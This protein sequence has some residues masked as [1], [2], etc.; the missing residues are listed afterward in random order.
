MMNRSAPQA[1]IESVPT[2][3][4]SDGPAVHEGGQFI[5]ANVRARSDLGT[6]HRGNSHFWL[7]SEVSLVQ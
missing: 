6:V 3:V 4:R 1:S 5:G 2:G 7:A